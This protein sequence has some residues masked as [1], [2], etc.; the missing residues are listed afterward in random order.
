M[1]ACLDLIDDL[2]ILDANNVLTTSAVIQISDRCDYNTFCTHYFKG[3]I[4]KG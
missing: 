3:C 1:L 4:C 2:F